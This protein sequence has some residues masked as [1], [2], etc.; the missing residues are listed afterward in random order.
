MADAPWVAINIDY[1]RNPKVAEAGFLASSLNLAAIAYCAE[2]LTDGFVPAGVVRI[3]AAPMHGY[4]WVGE[5]GH[6][7]SPRDVYNSR[8]SNLAESLVDAGLWHRDDIRNGWWIVNYLDHQPSRE[9]VL[10]RKAQAREAGRKG[11]QARAAKAAA[12]GS[13]K[14]PAKRLLEGSPKQNASGSQAPVPVPVPVP[15]SSS[16][17]GEEVEVDVTRVDFEDER[18]PGEVAAV[19]RTL[20]A[21]VEGWGMDVPAELEDSA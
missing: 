19:R 9:E 6:S 16:D 4:V 20:R 7:P 8:W 3:L 1:W 13:A 21:V 17:L 12:Q 10:E 15:S 2:Q 5:D 11:G 18:Y 14:R